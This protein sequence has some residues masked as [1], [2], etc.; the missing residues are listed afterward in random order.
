MAQLMKKDFKI[1][2][3]GNN[4]SNN[5][6]LMRG[7]A[8]ADRVIRRESLARSS[9]RGWHIHAR[10]QTCASARDIYYTG[11]PRLAHKM[12]CDWLSHAY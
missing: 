7:M 1:N 6:F 4:A 5:R 11:I 9:G 12:G 2:I 3:K 8:N 10:A